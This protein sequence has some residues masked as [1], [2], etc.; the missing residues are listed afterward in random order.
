MQHNLPASEQQFR[1]LEKGKLYL[2]VKHKP[3]YAIDDTMHITLDGHR[4]QA[5]YIIIA[6][7]KEH[8]FGA[9]CILAL[10]PLPVAHVEDA[11]Q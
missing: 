9:Y 10:K 11:K 6:I 1:D 2:V 7:D 8:V 3:T 5:S 4:E